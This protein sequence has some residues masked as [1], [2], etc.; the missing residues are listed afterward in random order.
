MDGLEVVEEEEE[1]ESIEDIEESLEQL[2]LTEQ[3]REDEKRISEVDDGK[4][5]GCHGYHSP[6]P[7]PPPEGWQVV[8]RNHDKSK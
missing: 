4:Y 7:T 8:R 1:E 6:P 5:C 2:Q 3:S